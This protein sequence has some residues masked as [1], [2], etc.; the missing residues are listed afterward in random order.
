MKHVWHSIYKKD[1]A[2]IDLEIVN[3]SGR[4]EC[5]GVDNVNYD[6][7]VCRDTFRCGISIIYIQYWSVDGKYRIYLTRLRNGVKDEL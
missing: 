4:E 1:H 5:F 3:R 2:P 7:Y 6:L